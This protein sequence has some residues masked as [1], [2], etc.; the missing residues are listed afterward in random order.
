MW[1]IIQRPPSVKNIFFLLPNIIGYF[2]IFFLIVFIVTALNNPFLAIFAISLSS[3]LDML[4]GYAARY[5][6]QETDF[7]RMLDM[8]IDRM[9][10]M[11][12]L[13]VLCVIYRNFCAFFIFLILLDIASH[14]FAVIESERRNI[15][16]K[17]IVKIMPRHLKQYYGNRAVLTIMCACYEMTLFS[18]YL[19]H[20]YSVFWLYGVLLMSLP[21]FLFKIYINFIQLRYVCEK[22]ARQESNL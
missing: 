12:V 21:G 16:H 9:L 5:L 13:V 18:L 3:V 19:M 22:C 8:L 20:F 17:T 4:D 6:H 1:Q 10:E 7:G 2:R 15:S 11:S 14:F